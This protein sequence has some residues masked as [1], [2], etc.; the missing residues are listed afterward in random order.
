MTKT[1]LVLACDD[2]YIPFAA[3]VARRIARSAS[4]KF[5]IIV[6]SDGVTNENKALAQNFC[7]GI[8]FI[9]ASHVFEGR[10]FYFHGPFSRAC[11]LRLI[12]DDI[13][14]DFDRVTYLDSDVWPLT[15]V[16]PMVAMRPKVAPVIAAYD[17]PMLRQEEF[18]SR[19]P[20][21]K[22]CAYFNSGVMV[23]DLNAMRTDH[24][25]A[26][27][28]TFAL[29]KP[30][31]CQ[32]VDQDALNVA[33]NGRWQ[34]LDWRWNALTF[35]LDLLPKA[36][37]IRHCTG[38]KPWDPLKYG[39]ERPIIEMWRAALAESPWPHAFKA[40]M[41][42][43]R[44]GFVRIAFSKLENS[45]KTLMFSNTSGHRGER[46]R[47][48]KQ[49]PTMLEAIEAEARHERLACRF[50]MTTLADRQALP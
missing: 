15:D 10:S 19:L 16:S 13:L 8:N 35:M 50:P 22:G 41:P 40:E 37:F 25:F 46:I 14:A 36:P 20:L 6:V 31:L 48:K 17:I 24:V 44:D 32:L 38:N 33:L 23:M 11:Y 39:T 9:E 45:I 4:E 47:F 2:R 12:F 5:P 28:L 3:V 7:P 21:S 30:E 26:D 43:P 27:A 18:L 42:D 29:E 34:V 49:F 1:A